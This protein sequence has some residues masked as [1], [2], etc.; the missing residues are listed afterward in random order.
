MNSR[1]LVSCGLSEFI[2]LNNWFFISLND[3]GFKKKKPEN[4]VK[5]GVQVYPQEV[6]QK[7]P[8]LTFET[9]LP[10]EKRTT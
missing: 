4:V 8:W 3:H 6:G 5:T 2:S 7:E 10:L 1:E 9:L